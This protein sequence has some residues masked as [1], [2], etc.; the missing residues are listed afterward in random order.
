MEMERVC[1]V[2]AVTKDQTVTSSLLQDELSLVRIGFSIDQPGV[3][4]ARAAGNLLEDHLDGLVGGNRVVADLAKK[5]VVP[6]GSRRHPLWL[7]VLVLVLHDHTQT[8]VANS[9][10]RRS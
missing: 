2:R 1:V 3:E 7:P 8:G 10:F 4:L 6:G 9:L 5:G